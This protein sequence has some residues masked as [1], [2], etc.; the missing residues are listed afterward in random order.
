VP[1]GIGEE[2]HPDGEIYSGEF[3]NGLKNGF[4]TYTFANSEYYVGQFKDN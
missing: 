4:G 3:A 2:T 1:E